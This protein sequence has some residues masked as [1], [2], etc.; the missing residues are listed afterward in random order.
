[1]YRLFYIATNLNEA[2]M[3]TMNVAIASRSPRLPAAGRPL[4][5]ISTWYKRF[6]QRV[7][8]SDLDSHLRRDLGL[9]E[10]EIAIEIAKPF[11]R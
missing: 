6:R 2:K 10:H 5:V 1:L 9:T 7:H 3:S 11:W 4:A 8:L